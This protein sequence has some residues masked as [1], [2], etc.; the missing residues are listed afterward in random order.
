[1]ADLPLVLESRKHIGPAE[2]LDVGVRAVGPDLFQEILE[3]NHERRCLNHYKPRLDVRFFASLYWRGFR[4]GN[5]P[6]WEIRFIK[7]GSMRSLSGASLAMA[8]VLA[9][10]STACGKVGE[11]QSMKAFK[12]ANQAYQQ[13]DYKKAAELY[14]EAIKS[15]PDTQA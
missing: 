9:L 10:G 13:Q 4:F 3:A 15:A 14:E 5:F 2:Q 6:A 11:L 12:A 1:M 8:A 7:G